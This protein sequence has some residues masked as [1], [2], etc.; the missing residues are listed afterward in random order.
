LE[1]A[2]IDGT[3]DLT[4]VLPENNNIQGDSDDDGQVIV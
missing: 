4:T 2:R 1:T 3:S